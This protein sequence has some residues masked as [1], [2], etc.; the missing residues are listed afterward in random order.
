MTCLALIFECF[1][2]ILWCFRSRIQ[3][4]RQRRGP[5]QLRSGPGDSGNDRLLFPEKFRRTGG[6]F[7]ARPEDH[8]GDNGKQLLL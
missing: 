1:V 8:A 7:G 5:P 2:C 6:L 3:G 4:N